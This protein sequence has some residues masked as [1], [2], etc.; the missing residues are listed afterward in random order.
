MWKH[1]RAQVQDD[2]AVTAAINSLMGLPSGEHK[3]TI[4]LVD[5]NQKAFPGQLVL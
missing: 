5:A 3:V 1:H 2:L 4:A